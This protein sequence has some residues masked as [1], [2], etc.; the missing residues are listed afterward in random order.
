MGKN[1]N[2]NKP[3]SCGSGKKYKKCCMDKADDSSFL[4]QENFLRDYK[5]VKKEAKIKQCLYPENTSCS[6]K[7]IGAHS[8]QNN[9]IL[10]RISSNGEIYMPCSKP[11]NPFAVMT[12]WGR[13]E[14]TVFTGFCGY[15]DNELFKPIEN[16]FFDK[17]DLHVFLYTYRCFAV[18]Y[19]K[20][21]EVINMQKVIF[22]KKPSLNNK[23][24]KDNPFKGVSMA[25]NDLQLAK[26]EFDNALLTDSYNILSSVIWEFPMVT[27]FAATGFEVPTC[28]LDGNTIQNLLDD[29][30]L[31]KHI[32]VMVFPEGEKTYCIIS[33]L[34]SNDAL[35]NIFREQLEALDEEQQKIYINNT[36]P[37]ISE[38]IVINPDAWNKWEQHKKDEFGALLWGMS[39]I[40][41]LFG[42]PFDR[43]SPPTY[44]L[45]SL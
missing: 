29:S 21:Q 23:P 15:H 40:S 10:K 20:K 1:A 24:E 26:E 43:L 32:F 7:I 27:N 4:N 22:K 36:L 5:D 18:E 35:F 38:N 33:W 11:D 41:E 44:D 14:A 37:I 6:E 16:N 13:K 39:D 25:I 12:K 28:D 17:S 3:C 2:A 9:K 19:H 8:I 45:F 34:K 42:D 31:A 30:V